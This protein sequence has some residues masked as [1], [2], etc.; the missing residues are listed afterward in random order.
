MNNKIPAFLLENKPYPHSRTVTVKTLFIDKAVGHISEFYE[1]V[2]TNWETARK[3]GLFQ[4]LNARTKLLFLVLFVFAVSIKKDVS[5]DILIAIFIM[6]F[7]VLSKIGIL[8]FYRK[9]LI[10]GFFF[11]LLP[12][13]PAVLNVIMPGEPV[14]RVIELD[15]PYELW[16]YHVPQTIAVTREGILSAMTLTS[17]VA[18]SVSIT[19]L[20]VCTTPF[21][22]L[23]KALST[24]R[25]PE[26]FLMILSLAQK[27]AFIFLK[28]LA[29]MHTAKK[30]RLI[31][32]PDAADW[33]AGRLAY[34][35]K[36]TQQR[37]DDVHK[38]MTGRG[39]TGQVKL[40]SLRAMTPVDIIYG[41]MFLTL[42]FFIL[43]I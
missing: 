23:V 17:R 34:V 3:D 5:S 7:V 32:R 14:Y 9:T 42:W 20:V 39:F 18:N 24:L 6:P 29:D 10:A 2:F 21:A 1:T 41:A 28:M 43:I 36:K 25:V 4:R 13:L 38:A 33:I 11:G 35:F 8:S 22:E 26:Y 27:Y 15:Q 19:L 40:A 30:A 12:G 37:C 16:I 31:G